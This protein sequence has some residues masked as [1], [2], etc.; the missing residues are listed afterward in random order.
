MNKRIQL[1][2]CVLGFLAIMLFVVGLE[3]G[4]PVAEKILLFL[5]GNILL[6]LGVCLGIC[7]WMIGSV[8]KKR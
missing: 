3:S 6:V 1:A 2:I 4:H 5:T 7:G 8:M